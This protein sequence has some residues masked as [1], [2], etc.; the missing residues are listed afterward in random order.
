MEV[1][2]SYLHSD[3]ANLAESLVNQNANLE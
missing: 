1:N 3:S 2:D